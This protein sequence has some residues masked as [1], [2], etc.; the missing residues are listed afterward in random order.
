MRAYRPTLSAAQV[1]HRLPATATHPAAQLPDPA[2]RWGTVN[3]LSAVTAVLSEEGG[4]G[5][6]AA[7]VP[8]DARGPGVTPRDELGPAPAVAGVIGAGCLALTVLLLTSPY[9]SSTPENGLGEHR[10]SGR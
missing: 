3:P 5:R 8:P 1:K 9:R 7:V 2:L 6:P 10:H 4:S